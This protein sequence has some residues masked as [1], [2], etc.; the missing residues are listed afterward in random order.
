MWRI[1]L[2]ITALGLYSGAALAAFVMVQVSNNSIPAQGYLLD[3]SPDFL[4]DDASGKLLA[5]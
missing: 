2:M 5:R 3:N 4:L 1:A